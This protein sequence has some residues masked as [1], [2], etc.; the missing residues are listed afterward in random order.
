MGNARA[1]ADVVPGETA[2]GDRGALPPGPRGAH[3]ASG[4]TYPPEPDVAG[5]LE[6]KQR[7][8]RGREGV[9]KTQDARPRAACGA[10]PVGRDG[11]P[12]KAPLGRP[13]STSAA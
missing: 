10:G 8:S 11:R 12:S 9:R 4:G 2:V 5:A 6:G 3:E 1:G 7:D 13:C